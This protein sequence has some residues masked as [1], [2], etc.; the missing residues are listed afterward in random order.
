M[1]YE[2][3]ASILSLNNKITILTLYVAPG[4]RESN[5]TPPWSGSGM[6]KV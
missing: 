2:T 4:L 1:S 6:G 5:V 3:H